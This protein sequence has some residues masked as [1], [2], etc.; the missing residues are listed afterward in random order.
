MSSKNIDLEKSTYERLVALKR[1]EESFSDLVN[2]F[3]RERTSRYTDLAGILS[4]D[5]VDAIEKIR[6]IRKETDKRG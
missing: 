6:E 1:E 3:I 4:K 5:T 2:R